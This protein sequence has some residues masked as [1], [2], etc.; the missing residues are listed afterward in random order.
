MYSNGARSFSLLRT[1]VRLP[2]NET[3]EK[4]LKV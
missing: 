3:E 1:V 2:L 4:V